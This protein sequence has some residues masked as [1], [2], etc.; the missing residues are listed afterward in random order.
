MKGSCSFEKVLV[1]I[2]VMPI[3]ILLI[4]A[5]PVEAGYYSGVMP[6]EIYIDF[7]EI[8]EYEGVTPAQD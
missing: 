1:I 6:V 7:R 8:V 3:G 4:S 2:S 5:M